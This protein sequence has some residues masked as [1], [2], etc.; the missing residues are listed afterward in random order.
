MSLSGDNAGITLGRFLLLFSHQ[1]VSNSLQ[2]HGL[3]LSRLPCPSVI[4]QSLL[5]FIYIELVM[6]SHHFRTIS[7]CP[8]LFPSSV[9]DTF[10]PE[11]LIFW[12]HIFLPF[13]TVHGVLAARIPECFAIPSSSGPCFVRN[14]HHDPSVLGGPAQHG[15]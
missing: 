4:S 12:C 7:N 1:V 9:S 13:H 6:L 15:S 3:Q 2:P 11:G 10:Q 14:V 5:R 8:L